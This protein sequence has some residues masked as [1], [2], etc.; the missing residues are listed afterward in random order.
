ME[1][2]G[3]EA[4]MIVAYIGYTYIQTLNSWNSSGAISNGLALGYF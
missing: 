1:D 4:R 3:L 2:I